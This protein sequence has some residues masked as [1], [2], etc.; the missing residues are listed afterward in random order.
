M[1]LKIHNCSIKTA[2]FD[3][4]ETGEMIEAVNSTAIGVASR[5]AKLLQGPRDR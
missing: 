4:T 2:F 5:G 3:R 1:R